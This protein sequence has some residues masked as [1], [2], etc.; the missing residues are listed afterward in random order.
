[1]GWAWLILLLATYPWLFAADLASDFTASSGLVIFIS[2]ACIVAPCRRLRRWQSVP[3]AACVGFLF[4]ARRPIPDGALALFLAGAAIFLTSDK[5]VIRNTPRMLRAAAASNAAACL[6]WFTFAAGA[7]GQ[8]GGAKFFSFIPQ[9]IIPVVLAA[10]TGVVIY[11]PVSLVQNAAMDRMGIPPA[12]EG[13]E[14]P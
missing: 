9:L 6:I 1:M 13:P 14:S 5:Q 12:S 2:G 3:F 4:E 11:I 7:A 10:V 8:L